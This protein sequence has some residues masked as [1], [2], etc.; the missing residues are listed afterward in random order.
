MSNK[1]STK[2][3]S[4]KKE[5][6]KKVTPKY[7]FTKV[8]SIVMA[9]LI[10][11]A[12]VPINMIVSKLDVEFDM[13][14]N[15]IYTVD[16]SKTT[17]DLLDSL[18]ETIN[19]YFAYDLEDLVVGDDYDGLI[20][21]NAIEKY[22]EHP[23][24]NLVT[25]YP[26]DMPEVY[27]QF[28][29]TTISIG[30]II[31]QGSNTYK[32]IPSTSMFLTEYTES[33]DT[34]SYYFVGENYITGAIQYVKDGFDPSI[35][36]LRGHGEIS[37]SEKFTTLTSMLESYNY[38]VKDLNLSTSDIPE[39]CKIIIVASPTSDF[40]DDE[41]TKI[42]EYLANGGNIIF[43]LSPNDDSS[44]VYSN[45]NSITGDFGIYMD[46]DIVKETDEDMY[47]A[48][49]PYTIGCYLNTVDWNS[50][51]EEFVEEGYYVVMPPSRSFYA[52]TDSE[53]IDAQPLIYTTTSAVGEPYGI[54][55]YDDITN[56]S[57]ILAAYAED[58]SRN[59][60]KLLV[61]G[62]SEFITDEIFEQE[63]TVTAVS[64]L[65]SGIAWMYDSSVDMGIAERSYQYDYMV[66]D[67]QNKAYGVLAIMLAIPVV[68]IAVG[69]VIWLRRKNA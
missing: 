36:F 61:F 63:Y 3:E 37:T 58:S 43:M 59:N 60:C 34:T 14:P 33:T 2:K 16:L 29:D 6:T 55:D 66:I 46:Y 23:N 67:S 7:K 48:D 40:T 57:L 21:K 22:G 32:Q 13:T 19:I 1:E 12:I 53:D 65:L 20:L 56:E 8:F 51:A 28:S 45:I 31:V 47:Y 11:V 27:S 15:K 18:D 25:G 49:D 44:E 4:T 42:S 68:V 39:D 35:C 50:E 54:D 9:I 41:T 24:I 17:L 5:G 69:V 52:Q 30:D 26:D 38:Q 10:G 62:N 64:T